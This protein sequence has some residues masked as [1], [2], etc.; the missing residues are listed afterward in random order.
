MKKLKIELTNFSELKKQA[1]KVILKSRQKSS[2][3]FNQEL[4]DIKKFVQNDMKNPKSGRVYYIR[5]NKHIASAAGESPAIINSSLQKSIE[6]TNEG[7]KY[8]GMGYKLKYGEY[9]EFGTKHIKPRDIFNQAF[10]KNK[11]KIKNILE[12]ETLR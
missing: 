10:Q 4:L 9:L 12:N 6:I 2:V 8:F 5:G 1:E 7:N 3:M 11:N